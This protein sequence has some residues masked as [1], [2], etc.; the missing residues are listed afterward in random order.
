V[1]LFAWAFTQL[2]VTPKVRAMTRLS[3][4]LGAIFYVGLAIILITPVFDR[5]RAAKLEAASPEQENPRKKAA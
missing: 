4:F 3:I 2:R 5:R 1:Q